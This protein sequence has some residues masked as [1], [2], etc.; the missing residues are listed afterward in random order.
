[1]YGTSWQ[2]NTETYGTPEPTEVTLTVEKG[3]FIGNWSWSEGSAA[4]LEQTSGKG[5]NIYT[6]GEM[7]PAHAY[8]FLKISSSKRKFGTA[9]Q[10]QQEKRSS[11]RSDPLHYQLP[12]ASKNSYADRVFTATEVVAFPGTVH[13]DEKKIL[14]QLLKKHWTR[15]WLQE[16][17]ILTGINGGT[18]VTTGFGHA[19]ITM[20]ML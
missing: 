3:P 5:I 11:S 6:H 7:L 13:I 4:L 15:C 10:N 18:K 17:Q 19:T 2:A 8:P 12:D 20:Q 14:H 9:W 1:M 16:D